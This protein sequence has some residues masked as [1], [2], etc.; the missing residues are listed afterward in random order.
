MLPQSTFPSVLRELARTHQTFL[1]YAASHAQML[2]LTLPQLDIILAL[3]DTPGL[4]FKKLGEQTII[5]KGALTG[6]INRLEMKGLVRR[7][8][9]ETDGRSQIVRLT[10]AGEALHER[11]VPAHLDYMWR[12]FKDSSPAEVAALE[13]ALRQL[14]KAIAAAYC[15]GGGKPAG[16]L[17]G[18][19]DKV[20][21][22]C[23]HY[24]EG[25]G[26]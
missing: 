23:K 4:T 3:G 1:T 17:D 7:L 5:T 15:D 2:D 16:E 12:I 6:I 13:A 11:A 20:R 19:C 9:S 18:W 25:R 8:A 22:V 10:T 21:D 24:R 14:R 26:R